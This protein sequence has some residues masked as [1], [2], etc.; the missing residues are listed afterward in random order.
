MR[1]IGFVLSCLACAR[2]VQRLQPIGDSRL[3]SFDRDE[4]NAH[5][6]LSA[7]S[8]FAKLILGINPA[9]AWQTSGIGHGHRSATK[10]CVSK[11]VPGHI[12]ERMMTRAGALVR[13]ANPLCRLG[14]HGALMSDELVGGDFDFDDAALF[15]DN[16]EDVDTSWFDERD[17]DAED[18][19]DIEDLEDVDTVEDEDDT[20]TDKASDEDDFDTSHFFKH[21]W[22][23]R[24]PWP[25]C[26]HD[27]TDAEVPWLDRYLVREKTRNFEI[28]GG[29]VKVT[30][31]GRQHG[32]PTKDPLKTGNWPIPCWIAYVTLTHPDGQETIHNV[33][34]GYFIHTMIAAVHNL[35]EKTM[36]PTRIAEAIVLFVWEQGVDLADPDWGMED[37]VIPFTSGLLSVREIMRIFRGVIEY[38]ADYQRLPAK[39]LE[40]DLPQDPMADARAIFRFEQL[41]DLPPLSGRLEATEYTA[42][43]TYGD[44]GWKY[45]Q[46]RS[47]KVA[48]VNKSWRESFYQMPSLGARAAKGMFVWN[49]TKYTFGNRFTHETPQMDPGDWD[50]LH[51]LH[52]IEDIADEHDF[53]L[54]QKD[55]ADDD[56]E[57]QPPAYLQG[58][59]YGGIQCYEHS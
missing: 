25:D 47:W 30:S 49:R 1:A 29:S 55:Y 27:F 13:P 2:R 26:E 37:A 24:P 28:P 6:G 41:H 53:P 36:D 9:V 43:S 3:D 42:S 48:H 35:D 12:G 21:S 15:D 22:M 16:V 33:K 39:P 54:V 10:R 44:T 58:M 50:T 31:I 7:S 45:G 17:E 59:D 23:E 46:D 4:S 51:R 56:Y 32:Y 34:W 11:K 18:I 5:S 52:T 20:A 8:A 14:P 57:V 38:I 40:E 19:E